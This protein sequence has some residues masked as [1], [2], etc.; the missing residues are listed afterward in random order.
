MSEKIRK[1]RAMTTEAARRVKLAGHEAE[2][3]FANLIGG[4]IY[5]GTRKKDVIDTQNNIHSVKSGDKKWQIFLYSKSRFEE[6]IGFLGARLFLECIDCFPEKRKDYLD[7]KGKYKI[8]LQ[9][10]M[11]K[12]KVFLTGKNPVFIHGNKIVFLQEAI[13]HSS[14]VD[15]F[16]VKENNLFHIFDSREVIN[17][18]NDFTTVDNSKAIQKG[19]MSDQ[20]VIFK[21]SNEDITIGEIEMRNDRD[22]HYKQV[23]FW[24]DREKTLDLLKKKINSASKKSDRIIAYGK[25]VKRF[26]L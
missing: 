7:N 19:Q 17:T 10:K 25:T 12:L 23:K 1:S 15:Y 16:T 8:S 2:K 22:V 3:E 11:R 20:K 18:I 4:Q 24:M 14:E 9:Q 6:S 13:F 26:K 21:L 5:P